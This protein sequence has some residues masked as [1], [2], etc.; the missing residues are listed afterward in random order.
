MNRRHARHDGRARPE[1]RKEEAPMIDPQVLAE[2]LAAATE[3]A[4]MLDRYAKLAE[5]ARAV[6]LLAAHVGEL[7]RRRAEAEAKLS[8]LAGKTEAQV[9][10]AERNAQAAEDFHRRALGDLT[11]KITAATAE[12]R[13]LESKVSDARAVIAEGESLRTEMRE[14]LAALGGP[15]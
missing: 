5:F 12:L 7:E 11:A 10:A 15:R 13:E 8:E 1:T 14:R 4:P 2:G 3:A 6:P 9:T